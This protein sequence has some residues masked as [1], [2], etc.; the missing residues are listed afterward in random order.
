MAKR[1][2][3]AK[4]IRSRTVNYMVS[5][6]PVVWVLAANRTQAVLFQK[7]RGRR[8]RYLERFLHPE[9]RRREQDLVSD[10]PGHMQASFGAGSLRHAFG[11]EKVWHKR[12]AVKFARE[13]M[14]YLNGAYSENRFDQLVLIAEPNFLGVLR[15]AMPA[16]LKRVP[17]LEESREI[18]F[19]T[20]EQVERRVNPM[21]REWHSRP[22]ARAA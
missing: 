15:D 22:S 1:I 17:R 7:V 10:R 20:T 16:Q 14:Q 5:P 11:K 3:K 13:L 4:G 6:A 18:R 19:I 8:L 21:I 2:Q 9:G 12:A